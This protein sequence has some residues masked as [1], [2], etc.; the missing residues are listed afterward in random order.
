MNRPP[1]FIAAAAITVGL[2]ASSLLAGAAFAD[3]TPNAFTTTYQHNVEMETTL[4]QQAQSG[5]TSDAGSSTNAQV[6]TAQTA[7]QNIASQVSSLYTSEQALAQGISTLPSINSVSNQ[8]VNN[9]LALM[10][11]EH[12]SLVL[13]S[14][15][16]GEQLVLLKRH[17]NKA[18]YGREL[19]ARAALQARL[20]LT[21]REMAIERAKLV[22]DSWRTHPYADALLNLQHTITELQQAE[23]HYLHEWI[24]IEQTPSST[25][26]SSATAP[27]SSGTISLSP[28]AGMPTSLPSSIQ[29]TFSQNGTVVQQV[30]I[31]ATDLANGIL[32]FQAPLNLEPGTYAL[33]V[34]FSVNGVIYVQ[35]ASY[36][37]G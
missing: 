25:T 31:P 5:L 2:T 35:T 10:A 32:S 29:A 27:T 23:I 36:T 6:L 20:N 30:A 34:A 8:R 28:P 24:D 18:E 37:A 7:T 12:S 11:R 21:S 26:V 9:S 17:H 33:S 13:Q 4:L 22:S 14:E 16:A 15:H 3:T 1:L 19:R